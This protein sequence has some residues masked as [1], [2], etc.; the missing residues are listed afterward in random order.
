VALPDAALLS[1]QQRER[2]SLRIKQLRDIADFPDLSWFNSEPCARH[3]PDLDPLCRTCGIIPRRHQ[4]VGAAWMYLGLPGLLTDTVGSGKTAQ[5]LMVLAMCKQMGELGYHNRAVII[6]KPAAL[7][8]P[9]ADALARL[10]PGLHYVIAD[11]TPAQRRRLYEG[12]WE[13]AVVSERTFAP[14]VAKKQDGKS[15]P[16]DVGILCDPDRNVGILFY[17]DTDAMRTPRS[18]TAR[19]I[20]RLAA[21]CTRV[22]GA[23]AT[24]L[25]KRLME[26]WSFL[27]PVGGAEKGRLGPEWRCRNRYVTQTRKT[28]LVP[29]RADLSGRRRVRKTIWVDNGITS[30]P[31][32]VAEFRRAIA[33]IV[34]RRTAADLDD[35]DLPEIQVNPVFLDLLPRQRS[36]Y[37]ELRTGVLRRLTADGQEVTRAVAAA[38]F[39]R[40]QQICGGLASLDDG[41]EARGSSVKLDWVMDMLTGDLADE[42]V[43]VFVHNKGNVAA[44]SERCKAAGI[45]HVIMWSAMTDKKR[46]ARRLRLFR[47]D[48][49][50]RVLIGTTTIEAS[51]NLQTARH[52]IAVDTILNPARMTQLVGRVRRQG[53]AF[54]MVFLH[55]LL[56]RNTQ[57][58]GYLPLLRREGAV[59]DIVWDE[60]TDIFRALTPRQILRMIA[61]GQP[62]AAAA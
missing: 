22:H 4:R 43:V 50:A 41:P 30:D 29:D 47:E 62:G 5:A 14:A 8:D 19:A 52:L 13:V 12:D 18:R 36:R 6:C 23:H 55:Q 7:H 25:Q 48:P 27:V 56:C 21:Q 44:L 3:S 38:A 35:V 59:S 49:R 11:G 60:A 33:P 34:L 53:S 39:G 24:P 57:E 31:E 1:P 17:D 26:L 10:T 40:G 37:E 9:W 28:I 42:K 45:D 58:D 61:E 16:G 15:R 54:P 32:R 51:L 2:A 20:C 46:R